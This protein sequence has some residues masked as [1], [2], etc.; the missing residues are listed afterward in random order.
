MGVQLTG[1]SMQAEEK[2]YEYG[3]FK[4]EN[5]HDKAIVRLM[6][7]NY[8]D[9]ARRPIHNT[10]L[11]EYKYGYP[12]NCLRNDKD[13]PSVCPF[14]SANLSPDQVSKRRKRVY[15]EFLVYKIMDRNGKVLQD[16]M[17]A[18]R[19]MVWE[20]DRSFDDKLFSLSSRY[21]PLDDVVFQ[22]ERFGEKGSTETSYDIYQIDVDKTQ[23]PYQLPEKTYN[24]DG[25][26]ILDKTFD[27]M[28]YYIENGTFPPTDNNGGANVTRRADAQPVASQVAPAYQQQAYA[29]PQPQAAPQYAQPA[30]QPAPAQPAPSAQVQ[31]VPD[32]QFNQPA[33]PQ[34]T[35]TRRR[36]I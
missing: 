28:N 24:P 14:C 34:S 33:Q 15:I 21:N 5:N 30:Y 29:A 12:V 10:K 8:D 25:V 4:L 1:E 20:R 9:F 16:F 13:D 6:H 36:S 31:V 3:F 11:P 2:S 23:Y 27:E 7:E 35:P 18:P 19:K 26:Q 22:I 17:S 32:E